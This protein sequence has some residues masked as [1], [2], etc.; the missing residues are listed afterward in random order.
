M[1][2]DMLNK[3]HEGHLG[4]TKMKSKAHSIL[5]WPKI[6]SDIVNVVKKCQACL[7]YIPAKIKESFISHPIPDRP[8]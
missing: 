2:K 7:K 8:Y 1:R 6:N 5:Y 3:L 4:V